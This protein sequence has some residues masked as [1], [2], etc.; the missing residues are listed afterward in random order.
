MEQNRKQV[1]C[2]GENYLT[3][4]LNDGLAQNA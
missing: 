1:R 3:A 2:A 4:N